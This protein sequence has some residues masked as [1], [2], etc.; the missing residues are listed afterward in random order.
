M[1]LHKTLAL[2]YN[3]HVSIY[4]S[5][6][7]LNFSNS[8]LHWQYHKGCSLHSRFYLALMVWYLPTRFHLNPWTHINPT[9]ITQVLPPHHLF[10]A[11]GSGNVFCVGGVLECLKITM[12]EYLNRN[13]KI[14]ETLVPEGK[15]PPI[16]TCPKYTRR[17]VKIVIV[18]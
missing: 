5:I 7:N 15:L 18:D 14:C 11:G 17:N 10:S 4:V 16:S 9:P 13:I 2:K 3:T 8:I 1:L 12:G 6:I